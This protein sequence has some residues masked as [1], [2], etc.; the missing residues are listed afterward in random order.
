M[1]T[2]S[3]VA[4]VTPL[5]KHGNIDYNELEELVNFHVESGTDAIVAVGTTG[6]STTLSHEE[7]I[8]VVAAMVELAN[9]RI[10]VIG[11]NGS[12]STAEAVQLT[13]KM[14]H[15]GV[16]GFLNVTPYY[17]KPSVEGLIAHYSACADA[18]DKPQILYNV[19]GRT[20]LD[21]PPE[22][23]EQLA[24]ID[25]VI[26]IKEATGDVS[27][28]EE[29]KRRCGNQFILLSGDDPTACEFMLRGGHGV[30]SVTANVVPS[31]IKAL[32][33][34]ATRGEREKA[35]QIDSELRELNN[36]LFVESNPIPVKWALAL[37]G[38]CSANYR[39]PLTPPSED[40]QLVI[41]R[42]LNQ[43]HLLK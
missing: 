4:L 16:D 41:E 9:G 42:A 15:F 43:L 25:N 19:P 34:A 6:E 10:K 40:S 5:T 33:D 2:G 23:V 8:D 27:R 7:H 24:E 13:V 20:A 21:M 1:L 22:V 35:E 37:M 28:V 11:G 18:S 31:R 32:V 12:N 36:A 30:I 14:S 29:L 26:G 39:L 3:I 38:K 17:N